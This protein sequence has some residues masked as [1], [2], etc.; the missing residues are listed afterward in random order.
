MYGA[1]MQKVLIE[2]LMHAGCLLSVAG[3]AYVGSEG[4]HL[5]MVV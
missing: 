3:Y 2:V 4:S 1:V 5:W